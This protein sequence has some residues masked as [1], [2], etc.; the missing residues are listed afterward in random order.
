M[1]ACSEQVPPLTDIDAAHSARC[2]LASVWRA[3]AA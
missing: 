3:G 1:P 2:L